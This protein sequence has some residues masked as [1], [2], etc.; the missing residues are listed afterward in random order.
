MN[1]LFEVTIAS[2]MVCIL[3]HQTVPVGNFYFPLLYEETLMQ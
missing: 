2:G 1:P 3:I